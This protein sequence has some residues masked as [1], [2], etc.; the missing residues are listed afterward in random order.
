MKDVVVVGAGMAGLSAALRLVE[1]G[2]SVTVVEGRERVGGRIWTEHI[3]GCDVELGA[4]FIHGLPEDTLAL[5]ERYGLKHYELDGEMLVY[6]GVGGIQKQDEDSAADDSPFSLLEKMTAWSETHPHS[7]MTF[8]EWL[9][10]EGVVGAAAMGASRYVEGFNA[11]DHRVIGVRGLAIQQRAEDAIEGDRVFHVEGGYSRLPEA[12]AQELT[13][14]G[15]EFLFGFDIDSIEWPHDVVTVVSH[16]GRKVE[17]RVAVITLP[18][19]LLQKGGV[20]F[21]PDIEPYH[22]E[23]LKLRMGPVVRVSMVFKDRWWARRGHGKMSFLFPGKRD[24]DDASAR[25]EVFWTPY[26]NEQPM[27]TAWAGGVAAE[28]FSGMEREAVVRI[29]VESLARAFGLPAGEIEAQIVDVRTHG[30]QADSFAGGAYSYVPAGAAE[31]MDRL[32]EPADGMLFFAGEH[33][34]SD[35]NWATVHGALRSGVRAARQVVKTLERA[36]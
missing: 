2:L 25:F 24:A 36:K 12:M 8:A 19:P 4:E 20:W 30:W 34:T 29:A 10:Q 13:A 5:L 16:D 18:L 6:D 9:E 11:S 14:K 21:T 32:T 7:D 23:A 28:R 17:A 15:C 35:G 22:E 26:P 33:T 27:I 1:S 31:A 3:A